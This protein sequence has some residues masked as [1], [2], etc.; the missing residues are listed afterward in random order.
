[1]LYKLCN[2]VNYKYINYAKKEVSHEK[3]ALVE[4]AL[5]NILFASVRRAIENKKIHP[6]ICSILWYI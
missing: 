5:K 2:L 3:I 4:V 1:M 6:I